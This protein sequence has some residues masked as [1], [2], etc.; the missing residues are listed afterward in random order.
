MKLRKARRSDIKELAKLNSE[1]FR[2]I[3][4]K[5]AKSAYGFFLDNTISGASLVAEDKGKIVGA[6]F[7]IHAPGLVPNAAH[8]KSLFV[9][10]EWRHKGIGKQLMQKCLAALKKQGISSIAL[11]VDRKNKVANRLYKELGF[12]YYRTMLIRKIRSLKRNLS[13]Y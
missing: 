9:V 13:V 2:D 4:A 8:I 7:G 12:K 3:D 5:Q 1:I 6:I 10:K 11:T